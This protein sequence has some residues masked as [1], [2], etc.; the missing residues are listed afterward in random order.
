MSLFNTVFGVPLGFLF[1]LCYLLLGSYGFSIFLFTLLTKIILFPLSLASQ[2]NSIK[3]VK[4]RPMLEDIRERY[5]DNPKLYMQETKKLYKR[6]K[7][8][9]FMGVLPLLIQ[10]PIILGVINVMYNPLQHLLRIDK[11]AIAGLTEKALQMTGGAPLGFGAQI[12]I[13]ELV[14]ES[15]SAFA[16]VADN[17]VIGAIRNFDLWFLGM[18]LSAFPAFNSPL[19]FVAVASGVSDFLMCALQNKYNVLSREQGFAGK[20]GVTIFLVAFS[21]YFAFV[22]PVA[23][24]L[25]WTASNLLT[26]AVLFICNFIYNPKKYIDYENRSFKKAAP[27]KDEALKIKLEKAKAKTKEKAD[28]ARFYAAP[29]K[30]LVFY[31]ESGG[32]YKYFSVMIDYLLDHSDVVIHYVTS[33]LNDK[34]FDMRRPRFETYFVSC[35]GLIPF[36][37]RMDADMVVMTMPDLQRYHIKRSLVRK[38]IEYVYADH[39]MTSFHLMLREGALDNYDTI[40]CCGPNHN[41]E[42]RAMEQIYELPPK[43]LVNVGYGLLD[44][45]LKNVEGMP[46]TESGVI[47]IAP[48]WQKD[49]ILEFCLNETVTPLLGRGYNI[50]IRPHPEFIKRFPG[51]M[52]AIISK[53]GG[54]ED[55]GLTIE[56]DF[57]SNESVYT[58]DLVITDWSSIAQEFSYATKKPSLFINT[59]MKI[60]NPE[61]KKIPLEPLDI[62]LRD[63]IGISVNVEDLRELPAL[64]AELMDKRDEYY[65]RITQTLENNIYNIGGSGQAAGEYITRAIQNKKRSEDL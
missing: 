34:V 49:N 14:T 46:K 8:S 39:G 60:M 21:A 61:Y 59:P 9:T 3:M 5:A 23:I 54:R 65:T 31:S 47:L 64:T 10:I 28:V 44:T 1:Y 45:L 48:S 62:S 11:T 52:A 29:D 6:E 30:E 4:L 33:D 25:F 16:S 13:M 27:T 51:K 32:F 63:E 18:N 53:Y 57:S 26:I 12:K 17:G 36:M 56:T 20:W 41:L 22:V 43:N 40:F 35:N 42:I 24:G 38:D 2:L 15:P 50:V 19:I 58:A 55:E 37:M 7:Y